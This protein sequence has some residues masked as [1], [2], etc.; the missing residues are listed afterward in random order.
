MNNLDNF[1]W[2][3]YYMFGLKSVQGR[4]CLLKAQNETIFSLAFLIK[5]AD[6]GCCFQRGRKCH[7]PGYSIIIWGKSR[8]RAWHEMKRCLILYS[9]INYMMGIPNCLLLSPCKMNSS[10]AL[11]LINPTISF[12]CEA[13]TS[14]PN[15]YKLYSNSYATIPKVWRRRRVTSPKMWTEKST[16]ND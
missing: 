5:V 3:D 16:S 13:N 10:Q 4:N 14:Y 1:G 2:L 12:N 15:R 9:K 8:H 11:H 7:C 6:Y